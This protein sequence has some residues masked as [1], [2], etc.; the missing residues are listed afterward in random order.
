MHTWSYTDDT[1]LWKAVL[2]L[3]NLQADLD[4]AH[5]WIN[6]NNMSPNGKKYE[7]LHA[8]KN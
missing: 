3:I 4:T 2:S 1:K 6:E 7:H 5:Q 8:G